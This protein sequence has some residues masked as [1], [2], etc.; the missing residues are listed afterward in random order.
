M[1]AKDTVSAKLASAYVTIE[2]RRYLLFQAKD[3]EANFKK[4]KKSVDILGR[5]ASGNKA[6]GW[7]GTFKL[8]IYHN[9]EIFNDMFEQYKNT[10]EDI[11][12]DMQVTNNDPSSAAGRNTKIYKD[13]NLDEGVLQSFDASGDWLEQSLSGTFENYESPLKFTNLDGME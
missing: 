9:T 12:F 4:N 10:G 3:F 2:G 7:S 6:S 11:Y 8:T 5:T 13:C 1:R